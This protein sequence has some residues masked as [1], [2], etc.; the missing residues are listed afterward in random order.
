MR[1]HECFLAPARCPVGVFSETVCGVKS[2]CGS[3]MEN[4]DMQPASFSN[5]A[6]EGSGGLE[7]NLSSVSSP[8]PE[9][10]GKVSEGISKETKLCT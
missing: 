1:M 9:G 6:H 5:T 10:G 8:D 4:A 7:E 2:H 3:R